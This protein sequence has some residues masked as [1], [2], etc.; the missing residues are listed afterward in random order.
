MGS[1][2]SSVKRRLL[3]ALVLVVTTAV[4]LFSL[5]ASGVTNQLQT[6]QIN[7]DWIF[8]MRGSLKVEHTAEGISVS[9]DDLRLTVLDSY[10]HAPVTVNFITIDLVNRSPG[11]KGWNTVGETKGIPLGSFNARMNNG[12]SLGAK[13]TELIRKPF[14]EDFDFG[15][16]WLVLTVHLTTKN[17]RGTVHAHTPERLTP[18]ASIRGAG[19]S[20]IESAIDNQAQVPSQFLYDGGKFER[21]ADQ[22]LPIWVETKEKSNQK[23]QFFEKERTPSSLILFDASRSMTIRLP[24]SG[25]LS[26][27]SMDSGNTWLDLYRVTTPKKPTPPSAEKPVMFVTK[28]NVKWGVTS[29]AKGRIWTDGPFLRIAL[30]EHTARVDPK[31]IKT[32]TSLVGFKVELTTT[33]ASGVWRTVRSSDLV[34]LNTTLFRDD[35]RK[36]PASDY[37]IPVEGIPLNTLAEYGL[38]LTTLVGENGGRTYSHSPNRIGQLRIN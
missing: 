8:K 37:R 16:H 33:D 23:F 11:Q 9:S 17:G 29:T 6:L 2:L 15:S 1:I 36:I 22:K 5:P 25:G 14:S 10:K 7:E 13:F 31:F 20:P 21:L 19:I 24:I 26:S 12:D 28:P 38:V 27:Y 32:A 3:E 4:C 30:D 35:V 34:E 18:P